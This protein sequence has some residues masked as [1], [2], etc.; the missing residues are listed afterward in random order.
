MRLFSIDLAGSF[1][2]EEYEDS[3]PKCCE[4][5]GLEAHMNGLMLCWS[6][7]AA[8]EN[9]ERVDC[10]G[11]ELNKFEHKGEKNAIY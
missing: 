5:Q 11:C 3:I 4:Y 8:I 6:L 10:K 1:S 9:G 2:P 7:T